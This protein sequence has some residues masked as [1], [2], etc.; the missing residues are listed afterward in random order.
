VVVN[1]P[2]YSD[3]G[4]HF[5]TVELSAGLK[6][7]VIAEQKSNEAAQ[8][9]AQVRCAYDCVL[10]FFTCAALT[11]AEREEALARLAELR[12]RLKALAERFERSPGENSA[13]AA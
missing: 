8:M 5:I 6:F 13:M 9:C 3:T 12:Q 11:Q 10:R 4:L 7:A 2:S 1:S